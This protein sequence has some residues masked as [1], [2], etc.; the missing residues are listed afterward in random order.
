MLENIQKLFNGVKLTPIAFTTDG[1]VLIK[2]KYDTG[3]YTYDFIVGGKVNIRSFKTQNEGIEH[4]RKFYKNVKIVKPSNRNYRIVTSLPKTEHEG[5][6]YLGKIEI[7]T[8]D[9]FYE[10]VIDATDTNGEWDAYLGLDS[11]LVIW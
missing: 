9:N 5:I 7:R 1:T 8:P 11:N 10:A 4:F 3:G 2:V 6:Y